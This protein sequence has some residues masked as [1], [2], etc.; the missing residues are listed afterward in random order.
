VLF[1]T[2]NALRFEITNKMNDDIFSYYLVYFDTVLVFDIYIIKL[3]DTNDL[4][5]MLGISLRYRILFEVQCVVF[6]W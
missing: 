2:Q 5:K 6:Y 3:S 4:D 1:E